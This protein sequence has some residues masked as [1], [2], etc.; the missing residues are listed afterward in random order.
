LDKARKAGQPI[1]AADVGEY[2]RALGRSAANT[3]PEA[4]ATFA[5]ALEGR[6]ESQ[7]ARAK[8][9]IRSAAPGILAGP[10]AKTI[11]K[12]AARKAN[13]PAYKKAYL[14]GDRPIISP[15][16]E[17][18]TGSPM[19]VDAMRA[20]ATRGKDR[21]IIEG[22]GAFNPGVKV[23]PDGRVIFAKGKGGVPT[24]PNLQFWDYT[25]R[26]LK[27]IAD[28]AKRAGNN[29]KADV[30]EQLMHG[31]RDELDLHV[32]SYAKARS[33]AAAFFGAEDASEAG[34]K[35]VTMRSDKYKEAAEAIAKFSPAEKQLFAD[36]FAESLINQFEEGFGQSSNR[37]LINSV[38]LK[39]DAA[40]KRIELALGK[41]AA[42]KMEA[43]LRL[44]KIKDITKRKLLD[45]SQTAQFL[46][47]LGLAGVGGAA[48]IYASGWDPK[49]IIT[50]ALTYGLLRGGKAYHSRQATRIA[51]EVARL[52][53]SDD[54]KVVKDAINLVTRTP[55]LL[56][57]VRLGEGYVSTR[58]VRGATV[59]LM[60]APQ[61]PAVQ[62]E[63][64]Q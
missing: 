56:R 19:M 34:A 25:K 57:A 20:A 58:L 13:S 7:V 46:T 48:G 41:G 32:P 42:K 64:P 40:S 45:G 36:N 3:S 9:L 11:L 51:K 2:S 39:G 31:L 49:A 17:Q 55:H 21:A 24:Y 61:Q 15:R 12:A 52:L 4:R 63:H 62:P 47:E 53:A 43:F 44:E 59:P 6:Q 8:A 23:T 35:F 18:L 16:M 50:G 10:Q 37:N 30:A 26:E 22:H 29:E 54:P 33:T 5:Q 28:Q 38:F 1:I 27:D 14:E 60:G